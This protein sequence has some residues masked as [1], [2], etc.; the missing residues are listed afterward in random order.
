[1][2]WVGRLDLLNELVAEDTAPSLEA[3]GVLRYIVSDRRLG[4]MKRLHPQIAGLPNK[5]SRNNSLDD[6]GERVL[7]IV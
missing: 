4:R 6:D 1:M 2:V 3:D 7:A 5:K